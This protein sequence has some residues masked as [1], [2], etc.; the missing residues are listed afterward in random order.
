MGFLLDRGGTDIHDIALEN[1]ERLW[2]DDYKYK[3]R[4]LTRKRDMTGEI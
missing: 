1:L 4:M 2:L 3:A